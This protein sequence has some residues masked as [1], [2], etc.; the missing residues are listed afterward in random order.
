M[1]RMDLKK[2]RCLR[3]VARRGAYSFEA[4]YDAAYFASRDVGSQAMAM[5]MTV[6]AGDDE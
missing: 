6:R 3:W 5:A 2:Q 1:L 4:P